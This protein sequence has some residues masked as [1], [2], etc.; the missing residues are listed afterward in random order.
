MD[1]GT[2]VRDMNLISHHTERILA[3][4]VLLLVLHVSL[5][6]GQPANIIV[7]I[8]DGMGFEHVAAAG[9]Y[10]EGSPGTL[11]FEAFVHQ[12][13]MTT[14]SANAAV[15]DSAA[16]GTAL[17]TGRKVNN[18][19]LSL[20]LPG[21]GSELQTLLEYYRDKGKRTGLVTTTTMTHATPAAFGAHVESRSMTS[22]IAAQYLTSTRPN[23]LFGGGGSGM[24]VSDA[25]A[26]GYTVVVNLD[27]L[28]ALDTATV[29]L[30]SG[31]F[32]TTHLP[33]ELDGLGTLPHLSDMTRVAI[34]I[35]SREP[36]GFFLMVEG[37][38][39]DHAAHANDLPRMVHEVLEFA[40]S[41]QVAI[42]WSA[43]RDDT[44]IVVTADHETGGLTVVESNGQWQ[45]PTVTWSTVDH[46]A[47]KVPVYAWGV[48]AALVSGVMDNTNL[49]HVATY[50]CCTMDV[51][52]D[53]EVNWV[54]LAAFSAAYGASSGSPAYQKRFDSNLDGRIDFV[55]IGPVSTCYMASW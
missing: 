9:M 35:L 5:A 31:Q 20:E 40:R 25:Q 2:E 17:A 39:I 24:T 53:R 12:A 19:V 48:N 38:K 33:Y 22:A 29:E 37:G 11:C 28:N 42:D 50:A 1:R 36:R 49:W 55:D 27:E 32:G 46:T 47:A 8:G 43:G 44:L 13:Q 41:V 21:D 23:V 52:D 15:T 26:A 51:N 10:A 54:D 18:G 45:Y 34:E 16:A 14:H 6:V 3:V 4:A 30:V 7:F